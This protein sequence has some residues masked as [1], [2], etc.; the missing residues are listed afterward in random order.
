MVANALYCWVSISESPLAPTDLP[1]AVSSTLFFI[2]VAFISTGLIIVWYSNSY[3][4]GDMPS[5]VSG[6]PK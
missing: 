3:E 1:P 6:I 4:Y 2:V 5:G